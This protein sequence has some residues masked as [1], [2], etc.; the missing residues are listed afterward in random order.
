LDNDTV[1]LI[2]LEINDVLSA[3]VRLL[4]VWPFAFI[5]LDEQADGQREDKEDQRSPKSHM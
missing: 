5:E 2:A 4:G 1:H 3:P